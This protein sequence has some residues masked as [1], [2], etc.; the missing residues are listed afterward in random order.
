M[1]ELNSYDV[2]FA[3]ANRWSETGEILGIAEE[4]GKVINTGL[5]EELA[6]ERQKVKEVIR[7][8]EKLEEAHIEMSRQLS[9]YAVP[10]S[11]DWEKILSTWTKYR[12]GLK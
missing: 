3:I 1:T 5:V 7:E 6:K 12:E 8:A 11:S 4:I 2:G 10:Q 9:V